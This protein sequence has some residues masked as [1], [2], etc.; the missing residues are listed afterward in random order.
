[1]TWI[2]AQKR[3]QSLF[4]F[5]WTRVTFL[6]N[7]K[8]YTFIKLLIMHTGNMPLS[9]V[10]KISGSRWRKMASPYSFRID[11]GIFIEFSYTC[12]EAIS[13]VDNWPSYSTDIDNCSYFAWS[14]CTCFH[15]RWV[16]INK[17]K[18]HILL[19]HFL[20]SAYYLVDYIVQSS[21]FY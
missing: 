4:C 16:K 2:G 18:I 6:S 13:Y 1:M 10:R 15:L 3:K 12:R 19:Q 7:I 17:F 20:V 8:K 5:L 21:L 14:I 11:F 9:T